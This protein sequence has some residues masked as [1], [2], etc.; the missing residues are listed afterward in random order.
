LRFQVEIAPSTQPGNSSFIFTLSLV[1]KVSPFIVYPRNLQGR[2]PSLW[3]A[4]VVI[5]VMPNLQKVNAST[6]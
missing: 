3:R 2:I 6:E 4:L 5:L 1:K